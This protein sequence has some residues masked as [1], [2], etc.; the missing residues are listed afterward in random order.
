[1]ALQQS[2]LALKKA[3]Y[4]RAQALVSLWQA[5]AALS[6]ASGQDATGLAK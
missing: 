4:A 2:Q 1:M 3:Q 5:L 6:I